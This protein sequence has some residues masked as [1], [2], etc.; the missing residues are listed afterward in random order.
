MTAL[1]GMALGATGGCS[2]RAP[3]RAPAEDEPA[4]AQAGAAGTRAAEIGQGAGAERAPTEAPAHPGGEAAAEVEW[5]LTPTRTEG[6]LLFWTTAGRTLEA[7]TDSLPAGCE[8]TEDQVAGALLAMRCAGADGSV[9]VA[10]Q[11]RGLELVV[12]A[13]KAPADEPADEPADAFDE[14]ARIALPPGIMR[15]RSRTGAPAAS[16]TMHL[17]WALTSYQDVSVR[18]SVPGQPP[19]EQWLAEMIGCDPAAAPPAPPAEGIRSVLVCRHGDR[20][21]TL[22]A[23]LGTRNLVVTQDIS[24]GGVEQHR[25]A[26]HRIP[27]SGP[28]VEPEPEPNAARSH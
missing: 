12:S 5:V 21:E 20:V 1:L 17:S 23:R 25:V 13:A 19:R 15:V 9:R 14:L 28:A 24:G 18:V 2:L 11:Q 26:A 16:N 7:F 22:S 27:L 3:E 4:S 10:V 8:P 6:A